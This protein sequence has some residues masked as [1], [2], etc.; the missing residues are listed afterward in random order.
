MNTRPRQFDEMIGQSDA[1]KRARIAVQ[2]ALQRGEVLPH[3]LLTS[4]GGG[5]GKTSFASILANEMFA[6]FEAV[7]AT[8][9][10]TPLDIRNLLI[11][12][13]SGSVLCLDEF[14]TIGK[15]A[16]EELLIVLE[17]G[18]LHVK[19]GRESSPIKMEL[20]PFTLIAATTNPEAISEP[21]RQRFPLQFH[22]DFYSEPDI[23]LIL[24]GAFNRWQITIDE[25]AIE[26]MAGR[27]RGIPRIAL[28]LAE[29]VRDVAQAK[30]TDIVDC[31]LVD[32]TMRLEGIDRVGLT[33]QERR[34]LQILADCEPRP[35]SARSLAL[36]LGTGVVTV[37]SVLEPFLVR[38][39]L[40]S[41]GSQG[42]NLTSQGREHVNRDRTIGGHS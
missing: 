7:S 6:P 5:L 17:Q 15:L 22:F 36:A 8:A 31:A 27:A 30:G 20:S 16:A 3:A 34:L 21:L 2:A 19:A 42:R 41:I 11:R 24:N 23:S 28:R 10:T 12:L 40:M 39:G 35:V 37:T 32:T 33:A 29:R 1:K 4:S 38:L 25:P 13:K 9:I 18:V 14:H 26:S